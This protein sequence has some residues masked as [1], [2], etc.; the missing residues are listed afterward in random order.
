MTQKS[1]RQE[2]K[3]LLSPI[4]AKLLEQRIAAVLPLD[5][6]SNSN[7]EYYIRSIYFDTHDDS[8]YRDKIDG[9]DNREK[10]RIRFYGLDDSVI[11]LERKEKRNNLIHKDSLGISKETADAMLSGNFDSL[12][13][14]DHPLAQY[15]YSLSR[16]QTLTPVVV[17]DYIRRAYIHP[18]GNV[19][20]TFD[21]RLQSRTPDTNIWE[22]GALYNV[23]GENTIL[24]IKFNQY[25]P[26]YIRQ[27]LV[28]VPG[29]RMALSKYTLFRE[30]LAQKQGNFLLGK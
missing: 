15:I 27:L 24:E 9:I 4:Q 21:T 20:I 30:N 6:N 19:R 14:Y 16:S 7:H 13:S 26:E 10:I 17:V 8:A 12:L 29:Q 1:Y 11:K 25:L 23:L 2:I 28:S 3:Q 18:V 5:A 22:P